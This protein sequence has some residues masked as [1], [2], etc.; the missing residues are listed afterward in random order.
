MM[1][2]NSSRRVPVQSRAREKQKALLAAALAEFSEKEYPEV[3]TKSVAERAGVAAGTFY[4]YFESKETILREVVRMRL[5]ELT[6]LIVDA[7]GTPVARILHDQPIAAHVRASMELT[8]RFHV[9][10]P[11]LHNT[12]EHRRALDPKLDRIAGEGD[13]IILS[14][15]AAAIRGWGIAVANA[16]DVALVIVG[17]AEG[18]IHRLVFGHHNASKEQAMEMGAQMITNYLESLADASNT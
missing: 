12:I 2:S 11:R 6:D 18:L 15:V 14:R 17:M 8:Y 9:E 1:Y 10:N 4:Q 3:T 5:A 13:M 7:D 16:D